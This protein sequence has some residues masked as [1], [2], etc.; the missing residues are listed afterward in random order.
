MRNCL[1]THFFPISVDKSPYCWLNDICRR[2]SYYWLCNA[3]N[4]YCPVQWEYGR[5][6]MNYTV[7]S[8]R[9]IAK[10]IS[11]GIVSGKFFHSWAARS[12]CLSTRLCPLSDLDRSALLILFFLRLGWSSAVHAFG[13]PPARL[14]EGCHQQFLRSDGSHRQ[15][16]SCRSQHA[17]SVC[18]RYAQHNRTKVGSA[19][20]CELI[21][22]LSFE[23]SHN[24]NS[25]LKSRFI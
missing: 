5:L 10:L 16:R 23:I 12:A 21:I 8:K 20:P 15:C 24:I 22:A 2:S 17:W 13:S 1:R 9:K 14:P 11:E 19:T 18:Q 7:V 25:F 3:L 4:I 6:N